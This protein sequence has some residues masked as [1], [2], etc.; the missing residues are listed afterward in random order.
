V[1]DGNLD[2][3]AVQKLIKISH[4]IRKELIIARVIEQKEGLLESFLCE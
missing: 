2:W 4:N 1:D 3:A